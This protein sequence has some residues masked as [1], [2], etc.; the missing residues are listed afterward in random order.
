M[1]SNNVVEPDSYY[2]AGQMYGYITD[3]GNN[4][5]VTSIIP[6]TNLYNG[7]YIGEIPIESLSA[8]N[9]YQINIF[10][11]NTNFQSQTWYREL[12]LIPRWSIIF[13]Q[14]ES[15]NLVENAPLVIAG[16]ILYQNSSSTWPA[17][18][19]YLNVTVVF[20]NHSETN[21]D[22][23]SILVE[24]NNDG[25]YYDN[26]IIVPSYFDYTMVNITISIPESAQSLSASVYY[27]ATI[28]FDW[29]NQV[30]IP[31]LIIGAI[32]AVSIPL[33]TKVIVPYM[34][35][36]FPKSNF[37]KRIS[38]FA[39]IQKII[40]LR[41][42][43]SPKDSTFDN[44]IIELHVPQLNLQINSTSGIQ[45]SE[46][47]EFDTIKVQLGEEPT[48]IKQSNNLSNKIR[49]QVMKTIKNIQEILGIDQ[50]SLTLQGKKEQI[51]SYAYELEQQKRP[52][53]AAIN[54]FYAKQYAQQLGN[55]EE[56]Q[57]MNDRLKQNIHLLNEKD[58]DQLKKELL[59][60]RNKKVDLLDLF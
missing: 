19:I 48:V 39:V 44:K 28:S 33:L 25:V 9:T 60:Q 15:S 1:I 10:T 7:S 31:L 59:E 34:K 35:N 2:I 8:T 49:K 53:Q 58:R 45:S 20:Y 18:N 12:Q 29:L 3:I 24:T 57:I 52:Y 16:Q 50:E 14:T 38:A 26:F 56:A 55:N 30:V 13:N 22:Q 43:Q 37:Y 17:A 21:I 32:L 5:N 4:V 47:P 51:M 46:T 41:K 42:K 27:P 40:N 36:G 11:N 23:T 6:F 54:F